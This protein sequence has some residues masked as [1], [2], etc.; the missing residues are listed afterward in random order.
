M[1]TWK[2]IIH[3]F[4]KNFFAIIALRLQNCP[5]ISGS[6]SMKSQDRPILKII[7]TKTDRIME[8]AAWAILGIHWVYFWV[9]FT[10]LPSEIPT[11]FDARGRVDAYGSKWSLLFLPVISTLVFF[12]LS[13]LNNYPHI[14]NYPVKITAE[15][16]LSQY[17]KACRLIRFLK[18]VIVLLFAIITISVI[19]IALGAS[20]SGLMWLVP[21]LV[22]GISVSVFYYLVKAGR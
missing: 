10:G 22:T 4:W 21:V 11:H 13:I 7:L 2:G 18:L 15:N 6:A 14:F 8:L 20:K 17:I 16:A 1:I 5:I 19:E 3:W 9:Y 12:G